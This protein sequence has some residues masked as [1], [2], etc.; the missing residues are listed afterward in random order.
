[1]DWPPES[2]NEKGIIDLLI[3]IRHLN[4]IK[5]EEEAWQLNYLH[6]SVTLEFNYNLT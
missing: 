5:L 3:L 1:M 6:L 2:R 4:R